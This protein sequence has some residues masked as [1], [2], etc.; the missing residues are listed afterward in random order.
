MMPDAFVKRKVTWTKNRGAAYF[1]IFRRRFIKAYQA[2]R[3]VFIYYLT[4]GVY[5]YF[6]LYSVYESTNVS[7]SFHKIFP[8]SNVDEEGDTAVYEFRN[9]SSVPEKIVREFAEWGF[10]PSP[11]VK[12]YSEADV[13]SLLMNVKNRTFWK[14]QTEPSI[15]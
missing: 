13:K 7:V 8:G 1:S 4:P 5:L 10:P 3:T 6:S 12:A 2:D 11:K 9:P 14:E 15:Y